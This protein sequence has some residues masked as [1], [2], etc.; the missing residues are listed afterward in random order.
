MSPLSRLEKAKEIGSG[1]IQFFWFRKLTWLNICPSYSFV[2]YYSLFLGLR[3]QNPK[4]TAKFA[5]F[6]PTIALLFFIRLCP[7][8]FAFL[9]Y[10]QTPQKQQLLSF[11]SFIRTS[12]V[13]KLRLALIQLLPAKKMHLVPK[14]NRH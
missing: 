6:S 8:L 5:T 13:N 11:C 7:L 2:Y 9:F 4:K 1:L 14:K 12:Q 10:L 3:N